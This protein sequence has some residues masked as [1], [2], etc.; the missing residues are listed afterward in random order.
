LDSS[1]NQETLK[2]GSRRSALAMAQAQETA[3]QLLGI[4]PRLDIQI[5]EVAT[6]GDKT[7]DFPI[8]QLPG[9]GVFVKEIEE[10]LLAGDIDL[11]VHSMKDPKELIREMYLLRI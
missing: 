6:L 8:G 4:Y 9:K 7:L 1:R 5:V 11:A 3:N 10:K 2:I